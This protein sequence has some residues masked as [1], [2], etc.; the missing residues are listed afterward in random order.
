MYLT[1]KLTDLSYTDIGK[2][3]ADR[4]HSTILYAVR[5]IQTQKKQNKSV[6]ED[7]NKLQ[8]FLS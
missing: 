4:D 5:R 3:F 2:A 6:L 7:I 1:R 8:S